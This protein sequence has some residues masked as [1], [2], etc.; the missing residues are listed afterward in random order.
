MSNRNRFADAALGV[1]VG[2]GI[3]LLF[4]VWAFPGFR[5]PA[6][7]Q[8]RY[9]NAKDRET[10]EDNPVIRPSLWETYTSPTDTYAQ[11]IAAVAAL[12]GVAVSF[13]AVRLVR[14]TLR[15]NTDAVDQ[16]R[17]A[18]QIAEGTAERQ[19]RAY[20]LTANCTMELAPDND[21]IAH[22][23]I[24]NFGQTPAFDVRSWIHIWVEA[25]PKTVEFPDP[26]DDLQMSRGIKGP[27]F[28]GT[29]RHRREHPIP[30]WEMKQIEDKTAAIYVYGVIEYID[31]F[32]KKRR[33]KFM[34]FFYG[35]HDPALA[36]NMH[37]YMG[38]NEAD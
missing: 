11:W 23:R 36:D 32:G 16:A 37:D 20:M 10:G 5:N 26:P 1:V 17:A 38:G 29:F 8:E 24:Q 4:L 21:P 34:K 35:K 15:A 28:H 33:T 7:Q 13:W 30:P 27:G 9:Q 31:C 14:D 6:Y 3:A 19:L 22:V 18:N 25:F 2:V 12:S